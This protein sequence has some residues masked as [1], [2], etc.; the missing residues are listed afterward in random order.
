MVEGD[1]D[2]F[3]K[4]IKLFTGSFGIVVTPVQNFVG[5]GS[6]VL[7]IGA[8]GCQFARRKDNESGSVQFQLLSL[9]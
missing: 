9:V 4:P 3:V 2:L 6:Q 7:R 8:E 1:L 5:F